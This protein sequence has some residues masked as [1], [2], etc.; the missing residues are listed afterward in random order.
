MHSASHSR[1]THIHRG[2]SRISGAQ[3]NLAQ[4]GWA[5]RLALEHERL[6]SYLFD[7][8][9]STRNS[10]ILNLLIAVCNAKGA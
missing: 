5:M 3:T 10:T 9:Q 6:I 2:E 1:A 4:W 7:L 8:W